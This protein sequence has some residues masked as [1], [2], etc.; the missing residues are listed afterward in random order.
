M[1]RLPKVRNKYTKKEV[2]FRFFASEEF[3]DCFWYTVT[4]DPYGFEIGFISHY[5]PVGTTWGELRN[6]KS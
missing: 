6:A 3:C 1:K 4:T 2:Y 5:T